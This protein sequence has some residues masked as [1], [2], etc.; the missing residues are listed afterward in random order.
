ML[1]H[2]DVFKVDQGMGHVNQGYPQQN[3]MMNNNMRAQMGQG[4]PM[5]GHQQHSQSMQQGQ[6]QFV[7][8]Y[9]D[10]T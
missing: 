4:G 5:P 7:Q 10:I 6:Q 3:T 1:H 2:I 8:R 9:V